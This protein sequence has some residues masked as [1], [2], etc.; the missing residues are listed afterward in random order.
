MGEMKTRH[1]GEDSPSRGAGE[2]IH[3]KWGIIRELMESGEKF[4]NDACFK[5]AQRKTSG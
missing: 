1:N 5:R 3:H 4:V 2:E